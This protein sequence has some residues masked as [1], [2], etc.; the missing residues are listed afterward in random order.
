MQGLT[1]GRIV[2]F[3]T[4]EGVHL[5]A[6]VVKVWDKEAGTINLSVFIDHSA[7]TGDA[8][9]PATSVSFKD[10]GYEEAGTWHWIEP[11]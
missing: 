5:P 6:I 9:F 11:A 8:V 4:D 2:H 3:I 1:E 10:H 7:Y